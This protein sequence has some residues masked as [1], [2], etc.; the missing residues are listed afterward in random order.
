MISGTFHF[1]HGEVFDRDGM[2][3][4][5]AGSVAIMAPG[6]PMDGHASEDTVI[7]LQGTGPWASSV[8]VPRTTRGR[9][10]ATGRSNP[11]PEKQEAGGDTDVSRRRRPR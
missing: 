9:D 3:A 1:A 6:E 8:S 11:A 5:P 7:Q 10:A 2:T 4:L